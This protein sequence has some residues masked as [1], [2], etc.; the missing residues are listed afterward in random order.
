MPAA[1][2][3]AG[4]LVVGVAAV[5]LQD[6]GRVVE[7]R[8][9]FRVAR[10]V[11]APALVA[12]GDGG[13]SRAGQ[14]EDADRRGDAG[15]GSVGSAP[16]GAGSVGAAGTG[17][18]DA[19]TGRMDAVPASAGAPAEAE[20]A[21]ACASEADGDAAAGWSV[22]G[23]V[24]EGAR[25]P[26]LDLRA[27]DRV[28][29]AAG[30]PRADAAAIDALIGF[31]DGVAL[32]RG[33][34]VSRADRREVRRLL[35]VCRGSDRLPRGSLDRAVR[36]RDPSSDPGAAAPVMEA[37]GL[38]DVAR[39]LPRGS[40]TVLRRGGDPLSDQEVLLVH[41]ARAAFGEPDVLVVDG[42]ARGLDGVARERVRRLL[43]AHPGAVV[44]TDAELLDGPGVRRWEPFAA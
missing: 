2:T 32:A 29:V 5:P 13:A 36:Y 23:A 39:R 28:L 1:T 33:L 25:M 42:V 6:L 43:E 38:D 44:T 30:S 14:S 40:A 37:L 27:G 10:R 20:G 26:D 11:L 34:P 24:V 41:V 22:R 12:P 19:D 8:Q 9:N 15:T 16:A 21:A 4:L 18:A 31:G 7:Y 17:V 3:T 35:G